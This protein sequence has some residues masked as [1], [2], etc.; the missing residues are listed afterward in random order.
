MAPVNGPDPLSELLHPGHLTAVVDIGAN[1]IGADPPYKRMLDQGLCTVVGF[2]PQAEALAE[3]QRRK[4]PRE[5]YFPYLVA[6]GEPHTLHVCAAPGMTSLLKPD[7]R[8]LSLFQPFTEFG[9]VVSTATVQTRRLDDVAEIASLDFLK[10]D[11]QGAELA[12]FRGGRDKLAPAVA[13]QT[14]VSFVPLYEGQPLFGDIDR[15]LRAQGFIPHAF[16]AVKRWAIA[17]LVIDGDPR[18]SLNQLLEADVV[19]VRDFARPEAFS[20]E[21]LKQLAL[22]AHHCYGSFDLALRCIFVLEKRGGLAPGGRQRYLES[23]G[24][25]P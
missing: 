20:D 11:V 24:R 7:A 21:Q 25:K 19:Y 1:P 10:I 6:D 2:E 17:P 14:E 5:S 15:E 9:Q 22:V 4:G 12:V 18:R 16:T 13:V 23:L 8:M 3:L